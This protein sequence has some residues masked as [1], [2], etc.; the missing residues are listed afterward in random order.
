MLKVKTSKAGS[1]FIAC[2]GFP[3]C[4]LTMSLP[5]A[6]EQISMTD[7]ECP[8]CLKR[9]KRK[10]KKF[11]LDFVTDLV[12]ERMNEILPFDDNTGGIFCV[13]PGCDPG[14]KV[15]LDETFGM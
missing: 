4:K 14:Y 9:D 13:F 1:L 7:H 12:N 11:R 5:R 2:S 8:E 15:L 6:L 10:V 3:E